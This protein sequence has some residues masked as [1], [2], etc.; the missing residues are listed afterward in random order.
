VNVS[1]STNLQVLNEKN[2]MKNNI[3][4]NNGISASVLEQ[5][6]QNRVNN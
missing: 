2:G 5:N 1:S 4:S 6:N 3:Q